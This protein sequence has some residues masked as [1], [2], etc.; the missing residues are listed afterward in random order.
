MAGVTFARIAV[1]VDGS[2]HAQRALEVATDLAKR[3][4]SELRIL[5]VAPLTAYVA[6]TEPWIPT[7]VLEGEVKH[8]RALVEKSVESAKAA[9]QSTVNGVCLEG[10]ISE[11][12]VAYLEKNPVDLLVMGSRGLSRSRRLLLGSTSDEVLHHVRCPVLIVRMT[13]GR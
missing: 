1:A 4:G 5:A 10:H 8:Y 2:P 7:E 12:L 11:E 3:Y 13:Q 9:G 6:T